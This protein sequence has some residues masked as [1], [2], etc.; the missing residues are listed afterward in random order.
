MIKAIGVGNLGRDPEIRNTPNTTVANL[1]VGCKE[2]VG[3]EQKTEWVKLVVFG[4]QA[5]NAGQY[6]FKGSKIA[7]EGRIQTRSWT[8]KD[9]EKKY[10]TEVVA[11]NIEY[12]SPKGN[13][14]NGNRGGY[15]NEDQSYNW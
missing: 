8:G 11:S 13:G 5:E 12:L 10:S 15:D 9:G 14:G 6:L 2:Y 3:K 4:K 7:F 1:S